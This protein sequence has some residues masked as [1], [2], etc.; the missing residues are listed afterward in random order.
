MQNH[1]SAMIGESQCGRPANP[2]PRAGHK[3]D[4]IF[5]QFTIGAI[6]FEITHL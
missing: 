4:T 3:D 5:E 1:G 6:V 2:L